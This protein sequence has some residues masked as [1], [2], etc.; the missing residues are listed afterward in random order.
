MRMSF[1]N[2][3]NPSD[4]KIKLWTQNTPQK[5][6]TKIKGSYEP[7][8]LRSFFRATTPKMSSTGRNNGME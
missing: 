5:K 3:Y 8:H 7:E 2:F 6:I 1:E 4:K